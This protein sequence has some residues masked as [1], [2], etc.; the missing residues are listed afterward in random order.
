[1]IAG[2]IRLDGYTGLVSCGRVS[3]TVL[4]EDEESMV[5]LVPEI[6]EMSTILLFC[7]LIFLKL[8]FATFF[9]KM[10]FAFSHENGTCSGVKLFDAFFSALREVR[11]FLWRQVLLFGLKVPN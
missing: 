4:P 2:F 6:V 10:V 1:M 8:G 7:S 3:G 9:N 11:K 5:M